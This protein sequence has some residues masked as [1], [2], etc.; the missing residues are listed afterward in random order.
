MPAILKARGERIMFETFCVPDMFET[1]CVSAVEVVIQVF[2]SLY[3]D[4]NFS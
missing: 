2:V 3:V 1:F 4:F